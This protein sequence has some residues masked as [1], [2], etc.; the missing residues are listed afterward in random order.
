MPSEETVA[1]NGAYYF[2]FVYRVIPMENRTP[3]LKMLIR[4]L[5]FRSSAVRKPLASSLHEIG[6]LIGKDN[7]RKYL[8]SFL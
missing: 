6:K 7:T 1:L 4:L 8:L 2:A 3:M 5:K